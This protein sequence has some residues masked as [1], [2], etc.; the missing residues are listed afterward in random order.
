LIT[1]FLRFFIMTQAAA[2]SKRQFW[3]KKRSYLPALNLLEVQKESY[4]WFLN[5]GIAEALKTISPITDFTGKNWQLEFGQHSFS[6]PKYSPEEALKKGL[7]YEAPL[8]VK[9]KL[10]NLQTNEVTEQLVFMGD[11]PQMTRIGTFIIN[12]IERAV[13]NQLVRSPGVFFSGQVDMTTGRMLY[14]AEL[15]P[16]RG[17]WLEFNV[18][19][20]DTIAVKIDR[21]RKFAVTTL[22]RAIRPLEDEQILKLF[23]SVDTDAKHPYILATLAKLKKKP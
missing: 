19:R 23:A 10:T 17:S 3:G 5:Q 7:T 1:R 6:Q 18:S 8:N 9:A 11:I 15:R 21:H 20:Y 4:T 22:L 13:V 16:L 14:E 12:G 2:N